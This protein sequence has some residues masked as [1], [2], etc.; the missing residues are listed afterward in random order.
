VAYWAWKRG[1]EN[2]LIKAYEPTIKS[3]AKSAAQTCR[4]GKSG[5]LRQLSQHDRYEEGRRREAALAQDY[6]HQVK[7]VADFDDLC[8]VGR[9]ALLDAATRYDPKKGKPLGV[10][11]Y[12]RIRGAMLDLLAEKRKREAERASSDDSEAAPPDPRVQFLALIEQGEWDD[13]SF[14]EQ[15]ALFLSR[16]ETLDDWRDFIQSA[17]FEVVWF[18]WWFPYQFA[19]VLDPKVGRAKRENMTGVATTRYFVLRL[20]QLIREGA[21]F[22]EISGPAHMESIERQRKAEQQY[23][24]KIDDKPMGRAL[25]KDGK[26]I[27]RWRK[28]GA[29]AGPWPSMKEDG[30]FTLKSQDEMDAFTEHAMRLADPR[31]FRRLQRRRRQASQ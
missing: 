27:A 21:Q 4:R 1:D 3:L 12:K 23:P 25:G 20:D 6:L 26:T 29:G 14:T 9:E 8:Q 28:D 13:S 10:F 31:A 17:P 16:F 7:E 22:S 19:D 15:V 2:G 18:F 24:A 30:S 11:A 5:E